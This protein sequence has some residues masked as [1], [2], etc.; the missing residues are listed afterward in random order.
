MVWHDLLS[1]LVSQLQGESHSL[2][3][4][5][6]NLSRHSPGGHTETWASFPHGAPHV[7]G[8][9]LPGSSPSSSG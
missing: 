8:S 6:M 4:P 2:R 9:T 5:S 3:F 1:Q 7:R